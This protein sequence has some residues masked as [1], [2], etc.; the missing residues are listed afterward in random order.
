MRIRIRGK[1]AI[2]GLGKRVWSSSHTAKKA[3]K[4][5]VHPKNIFFL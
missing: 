1:I 5:T 4:I 3:D 2:I